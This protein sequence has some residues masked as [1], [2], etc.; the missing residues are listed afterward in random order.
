M[1]FGGELFEAAGGGGD[2]GGG[3]FEE[4]GI[5][6]LVVE[7]GLVGFEGLDSSGEFVQFSLFLEAEL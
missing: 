6:H 5:G 4:A 1:E 7:A 3:L 2:V